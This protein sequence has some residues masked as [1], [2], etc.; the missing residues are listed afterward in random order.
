MS[1]DLKTREIKP[2][3]HTYT[4]VARLIG[5]DKPATRYQETLGAQPAANFH[6]RPTWDPEHD[7][8]D[9]SRSKIRMDQ[10]DD[11]RDPR[12]F[13]YATW[14]MA[15]ARQFEAVESNFAFVESHGM[16]AALPEKIREEA[17]AVLTPLRHV[18]WGDNMNNSQICATAYGAAFTAPAMLYAMDQLGIAQLLTRFAL[19]LGEAAELERGRDAWLRDPTWQPLRRLLEDSFV[20]TDPLELFVVQ[21]VA[22]DG[23]LY[24]LIYEGFVQDKL[25]PAGGAAVGLL[26]AFMSEWH[27][28]TVRWI[29]AVLR[30]LASFSSENATTL[31]GWAEAS[32]ARAK[33]ALAPIASRALGEKAPAVL[34][35]AA[36]SLQRRLAKAGLSV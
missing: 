5:G 33:E 34:G 26:T 30:K 32:I 15:R 18:A 1:I 19:T 21:D 10:W 11:L 28:E 9:P 6:Y 20:I 3:R 14:T 31:S 25:V 35:D 22:L 16:L 8:F 2:L 7:L 4:H 23:L 17:L 12:Q 13:Y 29:D 24:P 27:E 36:E